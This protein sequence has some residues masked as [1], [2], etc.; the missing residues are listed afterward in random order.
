MVCRAFTI[1]SRF[2][3]VSQ[4]G[5][6]AESGGNRST[7]NAH[8]PVGADSLPTASCQRLRRDPRSS[9]SGTNSTP[10]RS[11]TACLAVSINSNTS[12]ARALPSLTMTFACLGLI[13]A[14]PHRAPFRPQASISLP[15]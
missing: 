1:D 9:T 14:S 15:A 3:V 8:Y 2:F 6:L 11:C 7:D 13:C 4:Q 12:W 10:K 5:M